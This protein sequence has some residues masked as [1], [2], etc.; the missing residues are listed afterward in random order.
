MTKLGKL[1]LGLGAASVA[2]AGV[3]LLTGRSSSSSST[4][5]AEGEPKPLT[6]VC[7]PLEAL[8]AETRARVESAIEGD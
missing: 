4:K 7:L 6:W 2:G 5:P 8:D 1:L 3:A